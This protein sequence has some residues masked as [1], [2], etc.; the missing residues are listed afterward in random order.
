MICACDVVLINSYSPTLACHGVSSEKMP[1]EPPCWTKVGLGSQSVNAKAR[2]QGRG[3]L[4][5]AVALGL[6]SWQ[7]SLHFLYYKDLKKIQVPMA[8]IVI[9]EK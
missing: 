9:K 4:T 6:V 8:I 7:R 3:T 1:H 2:H 5:S